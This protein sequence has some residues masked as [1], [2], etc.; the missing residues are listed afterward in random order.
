MSGDN[1]TSVKIRDMGHVITGKTPPTTRREL[2]GDDFP[3]ITPTEIGA[4]DTR[5]LSSTERGLSLKGY[6]YQRRYLL[7]RNA[8]CYVCIGSTIGKICMTSRESFTNQ[9]INSLIVNEDSSTPMYVFYLLRSA[10]PLIQ[11]ISGGSGSGKA[12]MNKSSFE[13]IELKVYPLPTQ[14]KIAAILSAYDDLIENNTHRI[15][16]L[17]EIARTI[18]REWFVNFRFPGHEKVKMVESELGLIPGGWEVKRLGDVSVNYDSKRKPLSS[19]QRAQM[20]GEYPYY[21][22]AKI[23]DYIND[24]IFDGKYLL[25]AE[26]GSVITKDNR[27]VLQLVNEKFWPNNHTHVIQG[28]PPVS[29]NFLYLCLSQFNISGHIT[30]AAQPKITQ[31]NLNRIPILIAPEPILVHFDSTVKDLITGVELLTK[32]NANLRHTRDLLLPKLISG[33]LDVSE[34]N[35]GTE[36]LTNA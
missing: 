13:K 20:K 33:E 6:E 25:I 28:K 36:G 5:Y 7:P 31:T 18:Y 9:Q 12:I 22:A 17:E 19:M 34:L 29:T 21:G 32:K 8:V 16:I 23:L 14:R 4:F 10:T 2:F 1:L 30:G 15:R 27:P 11:A 24:F 35:I 26:D 3:F